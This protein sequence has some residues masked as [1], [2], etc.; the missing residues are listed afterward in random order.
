MA[1]NASNP[2]LVKC[3]HGKKK[4]KGLGTPTTG[5]PALIARKSNLAAFVLEAVVEVA[6]GVG[7]EK[8]QGLA[9]SRVHLEGALEGTLEGTSDF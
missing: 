5:K 2:L 1:P 3:L 8:E 4:K 6:H 9:L 7:R